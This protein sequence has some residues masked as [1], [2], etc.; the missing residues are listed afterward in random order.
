MLILGNSGLRT[1]EARKLTWRDVSST[2]ALTGERRLV[3]TVRGKTGEREVVCNAGVETWVAELEAYRRAEADGKV[4]P[5]EA[6]FCHLG[7]TVASAAVR[8]V[9]AGL[10]AIR[11][12]PNEAGSKLKS[13]NAGPP[14][15][16]LLRSTIVKRRDRLF[17]GPNRMLRF[18]PFEPS[19]D[20]ELH[21]AITATAWRPSRS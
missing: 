11:G 17:G 18:L 21:R 2:K 7:W 3:F 4:S 10:G 12:I 1:G 6:I 14:S 15:N 5:S 19:R 9:H 13:G 20:F 16:V 8:Y